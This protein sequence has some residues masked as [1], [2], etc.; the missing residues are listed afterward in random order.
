MRAVG[1]PSLQKCQNLYDKPTSIVTNCAHS[2][3]Y[4][5]IWHENY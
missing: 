1:T 5:K 3:K 4:D 2:N